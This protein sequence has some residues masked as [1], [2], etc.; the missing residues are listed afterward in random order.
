MWK[1]NS[2]NVK[3]KHHHFKKYDREDREISLTS[4]LI[5]YMILND[6]TYCKG[7]NEP[8]LEGQQTHRKQEGKKTQTTSEI[9]LPQGVTGSL[10]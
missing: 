3:S 8:A 4:T 10:E 6:Q 9:L 7:R 1:S 2:K 5:F